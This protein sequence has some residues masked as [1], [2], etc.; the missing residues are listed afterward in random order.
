[1]TAISGRPLFVLVMQLLAGAS[2]LGMAQL[3]TGCM[4]A[5]QSS[6]MW[7]MALGTPR[8]ELDLLLCQLPHD[9]ELEV[10]R[11]WFLA[12]CR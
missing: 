4:Q 9:V 10:V 5:L 6:F 8:A 3:Q 11:S 7:K 2:Q 1:M 12:Q